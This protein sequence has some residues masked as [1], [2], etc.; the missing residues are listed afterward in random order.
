VDRLKTFLSRPVDEAR[1]AYAHENTR[2]PRQ[3]VIIG[4]TNNDKYLKDHTGNRRFWPVRVEQFDLDAL[5]RDRDQLWAE[6]AAAEATGESIR[7]DPALWPDAGAE[8]EK[9]YD[10]HEYQGVLEELLLGVDNGQVTTDD[11]RAALDIRKGYA[12]PAQN[13]NMGR[14]MKALGWERF[15]T[16]VNRR[17]C[18][19]YRKGDGWPR[20]EYTDGAFAAVEDQEE[21]PF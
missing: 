17:Q 12:T 6:A 15:L 11:V 20:L 8:Q 5:R 19:A 9:R 21:A 1:L 3:C 14:A 7:L 2:A 10:K 13:A 4:T 16:K 18:Y